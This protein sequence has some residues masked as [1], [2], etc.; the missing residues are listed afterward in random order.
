MF[1]IKKIISFEKELFFKT[2]VSEITSISLEHKINTIESD[3]ISGVFNISGDYKITEAS[4]NKEDFSFN[5]DFDIALDKRYKTNNLVIDIDDFKYHVID[6]EK[7]VVN[8]DLYID[9]EEIT[10][11][12]IVIN[13]NN[14]NK[15]E[16]IIESRDEVEEEPIPQNNIFDNIED[17]ETFSTYYIHIVKEEDTLD[18]ILSIYNVTKEDL[19]P[20]NNLD[21]INPNDKIIIPSTNGK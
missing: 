16:P 21:S 15:E 8:I 6:D 11:D 2:K 18:K 4:I 17:N 3:L 19:N 13:N 9:G 1:I 10:K 12:T 5:I 14:D 7:L 20:Y